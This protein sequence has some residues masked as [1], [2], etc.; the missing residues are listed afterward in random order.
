MTPVILPFKMKTMKKLLF[1]LLILLLSNNIIAK[2][3]SKCVNKDSLELPVQ[4]F[5][6]MPILFN[7]QVEQSFKHKQTYRTQRED[8]LV[9]PFQ[10]GQLYSL[11]GS[12]PILKNPKQMILSASINYDFYRHDFNEIIF[13]GS[14][15]N[16]PKPKS[17]SSFSTS[18][19]LSKVV[20]LQ[21]L[22]KPII[23]TGIVSARGKVFYRPQSLNGILSANLPL[24][25]NS[26]TML[27]L[28]INGIIGGDVKLPIFPTV[29]YF[30][31][32]NNALNLELILPLSAQVRYVESNRLAIL[33]GAKLG[34]RNS[35][36]TNNI[37]S[38]QNLNDVLEF[39]NTNIKFFLRTEKA[40]NKF[41]WINA[42][43]GYN[44]TI[45]SI[46][47]EPNRNMNEYLLKGKGYGNMYLNFGLFLR[48]VFTREIASKFR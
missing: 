9:L 43:A 35:F 2:N 39:N 12:F 22:K 25:I 17:F 33:A 11:F 6:S 37:T 8:K 20:F 38:L 14:N 31:K 4:A 10:D 44:H 29:S 27:T 30:A 26:K 16:I 21:K 46:L 41:L 40:L 19:N 48:P 47:N 32:I 18:L 7:F 28:G 36:I 23:L 15:S 1:F 5:V 24:K 34:P 42:E 3:E 45:Q 13:R